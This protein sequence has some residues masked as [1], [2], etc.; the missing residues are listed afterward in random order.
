MRAFRQRHRDSLKIV[1]GFFIMC[2][3]NIVIVDYG[4]GNLHSVNKAVALVGGSP[5]ITGDKAVIAA[6]EKMI[7]PGVGAFGDCMANLEK[8]G[9]IPA[10]KAHI[11]AGKP[12]LGICLGMQVLFEESE[13][14]PGVK[15]L[16]VFPG[17]VVRIPTTLK[18]PHMGW[19]RLQL[20]MYSPLLAGAEGQY[21]YF[22]H[23]YC[24]SPKD[25]DV[26][27]AVCGY[28]AEVVAAVGQGNVYG[29]QFHPEK[30]STVGLEMLKR[31]VEL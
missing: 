6:T 7:L 18:I 22:V 9:V 17:K 12:F 15:G 13:E 27:T 3:R 25:E 20:K 21:V 14:A 5:V 26:I 8:A 30:S 4:M 24:C 31:F 29:F 1:L 11:A 10:I 16:G 23:S 19:N 28:D 2:N